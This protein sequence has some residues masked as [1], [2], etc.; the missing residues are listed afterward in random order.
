MMT[1][2]S[3]PD[4]RTVETISFTVGYV[5]DLLIVA[6]GIFTVTVVMA[7]LWPVVLKI[8]GSAMVLSVGVRAV[9]RRIRRSFP[10]ES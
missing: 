1:P 5:L 9:L 6:W 10:I 2:S 4:P 3:V 8:L 7:A